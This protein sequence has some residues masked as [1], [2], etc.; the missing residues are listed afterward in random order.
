VDQVDPDSDP[1]SEHWFYDPD[2]DES[3]LKTFWIRI[4]VRIRFGLVKQ[5]PGTHPCTILA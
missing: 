3:A 5:D 1:D 4:R 2:V